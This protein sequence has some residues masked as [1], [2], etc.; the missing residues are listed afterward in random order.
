MNKRHG[1]SYLTVTKESEPA[2][3]KMAEEFKKDFEILITERNLV[4][5]QV[6]NSDKTAFFYKMFPL[7]TLTVES[8][9]QHFVKKS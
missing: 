1:I 4:L 7:K 6:C 8:D 3:E 9:Q 5:A 2:D